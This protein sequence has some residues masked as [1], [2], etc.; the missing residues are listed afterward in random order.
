MA[1]QTLT[2]RLWKTYGFQRKQVGGTHRLGVW[3]GNAVKL[4][5]D[6]HCT[7]INVMKLIQYF[8]KKKIRER[9]EIDTIRNVKG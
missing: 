2:Y 7:T 9:T 8:K 3:H 6:D 1:E 5:C 4:S